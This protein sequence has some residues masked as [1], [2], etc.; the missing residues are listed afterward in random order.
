MSTLNHQHHSNGTFESSANIKVA[1]FLNL[2]F[3]L[4]EFIGGL[5]INSL[6][7][8][9]DA[10]HDLGDSFSIGASLYLEKVAQRSRDEIFTYGYRRFSLLA[11]LINSVVLIVGSTIILFHAIPRIFHPESVR[12]D[13]MLWFALAGILVN[14]VA[15]WRLHKGGTMNENVV[16][17]HLL[18]DVLGW[19]AIL[20]VGIILQFKDWP[21]LD[22]LVSVLFTGVILFHV[23][24]TF[25]EILKIFLQ[26]IPSNIELEKLREDLQSEPDILDI[27]DL[28]IWSLDGKHHILTAHLMVDDKI[29]EDEIQTVKNRV[30]D[31]ARKWE[32]IH[33]TLEIER[34][35]YLCPGDNHLP[36]Q[37]GQ[38]NGTVRTSYN[39]Q[40]D[41]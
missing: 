41:H 10:V 6:A 1:F 15:A 17:W 12:A 13:G 2:G 31:K 34:E 25:K 38:A 35:K 36:S 29:P 8:L 19:V 22:P 14:G 28:H 11:A 23:I 27:H 16:S 32:I 33:S 20:I 7:I 24:Q 21:I 39:K 5:W 9:S 30:Y 26:S 18:E 37:T 3:T 40:D 4:L